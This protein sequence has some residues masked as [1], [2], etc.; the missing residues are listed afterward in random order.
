MNSTP[1]SN[2]LTDKSGRLGEIRSLNRHL[3]S[4][5]DVKILKVVAMVDAL[6]A[7]GD[8]HVG[9]LGRELHG[10]RATDA[11]RTARDEHALPCVRHHA[12]MEHG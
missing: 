12:S 5:Q 7:R 4:A 6:P 3:V 9:A 1:G 2:P 10:R 8:A 11:F